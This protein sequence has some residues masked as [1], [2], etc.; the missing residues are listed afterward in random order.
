[1]RKVSYNVQLRPQQSDQTCWY[2]AAKMIIEFHR[3]R[4]MQCTVVGGEI[5]QPQ[6]DIAVARENIGLSIS[7]VSQFASKYGFKTAWICPTGDG[8]LDLLEKG[9]PLWYGGVW[10]KNSS[11]S[12]GHAVVITGGTISRIKGCI[13][14]INNPWP[15]NKGAR[16]QWPYARFFSTL[17]QNEAVPFLY[18]G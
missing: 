14:D 12:G 1:M 10:T 17:S 4:K 18:L 9:G 6:V 13:L 5:G 8:V 3:S 11:Y 2:A 16:E 7:M 15:P